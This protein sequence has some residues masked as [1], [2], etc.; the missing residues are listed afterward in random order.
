MNYHFYYNQIGLI[1]GLAAGQRI[2]PRGLRTLFKNVSL[3]SMVCVCLVGEQHHRTNK[4]FGLSGG[5]TGD[6]Q[7]I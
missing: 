6:R 4:I 2:T 3:R 5:G 7:I 1:K